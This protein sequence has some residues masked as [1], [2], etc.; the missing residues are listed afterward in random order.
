MASLDG[1]G[2]EVLE[3]VSDTYR[4]NR[5]GATATKEFIVSGPPMDPMAPVIGQELL[6]VVNEAGIPKIGDSY[7]GTG[8]PI[9]D[10][11][12]AEEVSDGDSETFR[13]Y[14]VK[15]DYS[16]VLNTDS[17]NLIEWDGVA[18][19]YKLLHDIERVY[20]QPQS[21][22]VH[23]DSSKAWNAYPPAQLPGTPLIGLDEDGG[24]KG[25]DIQD[26]SS[27]LIVEKN[28]LLSDINWNNLVAELG[29]TNSDA[30]NV[31]YGFKQYECLFT[32]LQELGRTQEWETGGVPAKDVIV[33]LQFKFQISPR[34]VAND[35]PTFT[36]P[37]G[38]PFQVTNGKEGWQYLWSRPISIGDE[39]NGK[40]ETRTEVVQV[41]DV[42]ESANFVA[43]L[44]LTG[45][46]P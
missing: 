19:S 37:D 20:V 17:L 21:Q 41:H 22:T 35:L 31:F 25:V 46:M 9:C 36:G 39:A 29:K 16:L 10:S 42:Y 40:V 3:Q 14:R 1:Q 7:S 26:F 45:V 38:V 12:V 23:I 24:V 11:V 27:V 28:I 18:G 34:L 13:L 43:T 6:N 33:R 15:V 5:S 44:G 4:L 8:S 30:D 2:F 32:G